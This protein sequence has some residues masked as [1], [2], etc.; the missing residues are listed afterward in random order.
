MRIRQWKHKL[1]FKML[2]LFTTAAVLMLSLLG[3]FIYQSTKSTLRQ[4]AIKYNTAL[5]QQLT[6]NLDVYFNNV[7]TILYTIAGNS[8]TA[9]AL[10]TYDDNYQRQVDSNWFFH[11]LLLS[12][13]QVNPFLEDLIIIRNGRAIYNIAA[14]SNDRFYE[15]QHA[16][17]FSAAGLGAGKVVF[18]GPHEHNYYINPLPSGQVVSALIAIYSPFQT[19]KE[20]QG[21]LL[22]DISLAEIQSLINQ[23]GKAARGDLYVL[24]EKNE[25]LL[26]SFS[27][28]EA[29]H[30]THVNLNLPERPE[31]S[32]VFFDAVNGI[33]SLVIFNSSSTTGWK[34]AIVIPEATIFES[35][36][37]IRWATA[38]VVSISIVI[39]VALSYVLANAITKP[40]SRLMATMAQVGRGQYDQ[41]VEV[42]T[43]DEIGLL[44]KEYNKMLRKLDHLVKENY[45]VAI[46]SKEARY[47]ALR[48]KF[49]PHFFNNVL[50][51]IRGLA[52]LERHSD[53]EQLI[54]QL[55]EMFA[56]V[57]YEDEEWVDL[58]KEMNYLSLYLSSYQ[59]KGSRNFSFKI[60]ADDAAKNVQVP[61]LLLQPLVENALK[62]GGRKDGAPL[63]ICV[64]AI[65]ANDKVKIEV[66][67]NGDG[68]E[69]LR[70]DML[71]RHLLGEHTGLDRVGIIHV[72]ERLKLAYDS[73]AKL[74]VS[75]TTGKGTTA[76]I[77]IPAITSR[78]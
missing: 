33:Q 45:L 44:T 74:E 10:E 23:T 12:Y 42:T 19:S 76:A 11:A 38:L 18:I 2:V 60:Q 56:Y 27:L 63:E 14:N 66:R 31:E 35:T 20:P 78:K 75:S 7:S 49:N 32:G 53:I 48:A 26:Q 29:D 71:N 57:L 51:T 13:S 30:T 59:W 3:L 6:S 43:Q 36:G 9:A 52:V 50:Q 47:Q 22:A 73:D 39:M 15:F 37:K 16:P 62:H 34:T 1:K 64:I 69:P 68:I 40:L 70:L 58:E 5:V 61:K 8:E 21:H 46:E 4:D 55:G 54:E 72:K 24:N 28:N 67:D 65:M 41:E 25:V 77:V 17:W